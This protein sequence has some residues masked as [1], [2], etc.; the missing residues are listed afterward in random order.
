MA[1]HGLTV[2]GNKV[3]GRICGR[4]KQKVIRRRRKLHTKP[5][6]ITW[7]VHLELWSENLK[8]NYYV[9]DLGVTW[10]ILLQWIIEKWM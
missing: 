4:K 3:M 1:Y 6:T 7:A 10:R 8:G 2:F 5:R 9:W